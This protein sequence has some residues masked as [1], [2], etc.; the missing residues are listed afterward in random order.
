MDYIVPNSNIKLD[1]SKFGFGP[2]APNSIQNW[3]G[4]QEYNSFLN[5]SKDPIKKSALDKLSWTADNVKYRANDFGYRMDEN[6]S[7]IIGNECAVY[8]G[9][10]IT[11]GVGL[12]LEDT[13]GWKHSQSRGLEY[14]NLSWPGS[15]VE[16]YYRMLKV[17]ASTLNI[18]RV[19]TLGSFFGRREILSS[20]SNATHWSGNK[21]TNVIMLGHWNKDNERAILYS[22]ISDNDELKI[23]YLR[24]WDSIIGICSLNNIELLIL[25]D[26]HRKKL[27]KFLDNN[28]RDLMHTGPKWHTEIANSSESVWE[29]LA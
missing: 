28:A 14:V 1:I 9:C 11:F 18:K 19:Y 4:S 27:S 22:G 5:H 6:F 7:T 20:T 3:A 12:N 16:T 29:R 23:S 2:L 8:L 24:T 17:W 10:S 26:S 13:W 15:G 25:S 21:K